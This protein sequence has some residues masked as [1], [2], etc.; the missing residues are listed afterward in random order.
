LQFIDQLPRRHSVPNPITAVQDQYL[1][2]A[3]QGQETATAMVGAWTRTVQQTA[4]KTPVAAGQAAANTVIDQLSDFAHTMIDMQR[5]LSKQL[6]SQSLAVAEDVAQQATTA[7]TETTEK[8]SRAA[9][10]GGRS[11]SA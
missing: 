8:I 2:F 6:V 11:T 3:R 4:L 7:A 1:A 9:H 5:N 10:R